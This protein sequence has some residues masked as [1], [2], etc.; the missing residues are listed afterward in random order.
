MPRTNWREDPVLIYEH[1]KPTG[2]TIRRIIV[3]AVSTQ[4]LCKERPDALGF[5]RY[6]SAVAAVHKTQEGAYYIERTEPLIRTI[7]LRIGPE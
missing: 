7:A 4:H 5:C 1:G 2:K 6:D 3:H